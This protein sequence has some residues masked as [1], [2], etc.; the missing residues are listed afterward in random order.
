MKPT[1]TRGIAVVISTIGSGALDTPHD[2]GRL[3]FAQR[4]SV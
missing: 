1:I 4:T 2:E 3:P